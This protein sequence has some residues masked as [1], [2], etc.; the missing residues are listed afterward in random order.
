MMGT[1]KVYMDTF[2]R[3]VKEGVNQLIRQIWEF[4]EFWTPEEQ[5]VSSKITDGDIRKEVT[6]KLNVKQVELCLLYVICF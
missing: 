3:L 5:V 2:T 1:E 4:V 6:Q